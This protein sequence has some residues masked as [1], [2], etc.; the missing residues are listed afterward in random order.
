MTAPDNFSIRP[1]GLA[2]SADL[3]AWRNDP[4]TRANSRNTAEVAPGDH[5]EWLGRAL[6]DPNRRLWIGHVRDAS[7]GTV[8]I[9]RSQ[10]GQLE[11]SVS[12]APSARGRGHGESLV[13]AAVAEAT[14]IW[15]RAAIRA[16]VKP[17]N[18]A[19][20]ALFER[21]GFR[22]VEDR[23]EFLDYELPP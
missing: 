14:T 4:L 23:G 17:D 20:V 18:L 3:L 21:C 6:A 2:D 12:V 11:I 7:V 9:L 5:A 16:V 8:S 13:R 10:D 1:A 19:S 15:P 22:L